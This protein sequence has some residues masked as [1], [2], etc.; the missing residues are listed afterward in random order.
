[1]KLSAS[2][3][4]SKNKEL[5]E[6]IHD[7]DL[8]QI[9]Y[10]HIDSIEDTSVFEK[11]DL[12]SHNSSIPIDLHLI[13]NNPLFYIDEIKSRDIKQVS[14]QYE[15]LPKDFVFPKMKDTKIGLAIHIQNHN[16]NEIISLYKNQLDYFLLMMTTP[17]VSGGLF[18]IHNLKRIHQLVLENPN[19]IFQ[20][21]GGVNNEIAY[22]L[23]IFGVDTVVIGSYMMNHKDIGAAVLNLKS[24]SSSSDIFVS[25]FMISRD[26]LPVFNVENSTIKEVLIEMQHSKLGIVFCEK[27]NKFEGIITNADIRKYLLSNHYDPNDSIDKCLNQNPKKILETFT[28]KKMLEYINDCGFPILVLPIVNLSNNLLG[29]I[30]FHKLLKSD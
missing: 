23:R 6:V 7:L 14:F 8:Y 18:E 2:V 19:L 3:F 1:M 15:N 4:S 30:S 22:V 24:K 26:Y 10:C 9:D 17:G 12:I 25:D 16:I 5:L 13:T 20:V 21:D 27:N 29:A 11:I 28:I